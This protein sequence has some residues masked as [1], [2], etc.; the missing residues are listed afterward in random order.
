LDTL[1]EPLFQ[2]ITTIPRRIEMSKTLFALLP[3]AAMLALAGCQ[4]V[5]LT[6]T[7]EP[8]ALD[9]ALKRARFE[10]NC[11][12]ATASVLSKQTIEPAFQTLRFNGVERAE[13]TIGVA[14][15]NQRTTLVVIC[16]DGADGC[17][18]ADGR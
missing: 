10:M 11:P 5:P 7:K 4:T 1:V 16:A 8:M 2:S 9:F 17:F 15:C 14:G 12:A 13:F 6:T 18:A 3:L